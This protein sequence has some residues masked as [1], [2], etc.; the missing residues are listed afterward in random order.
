MKSKIT[1]RHIIFYSGTK[2][3][4]KNCKMQKNQNFSKTGHFL[5]KKHTKTQCSFHQ[6]YTNPSQKI[7]TTQI[8]WFAERLSPLFSFFADKYAMTVIRCWTEQCRVIKQMQSVS[9]LPRL[10]RPIS[11]KSDSITGS[12]KKRKRI[13]SC[14]E[15]RRHI[16]NWIR[17]VRS[18]TTV[19]VARTAKDGDF[20]IFV[21]CLVV[22]DGV[23]LVY[24]L[25]FWKI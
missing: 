25:I 7:S 18:V 22:R 4:H 23:Y 13:R 21:C 11:A 5:F 19:L 9:Q 1:S 8:F 12:I 15:K 10:I 6:K 16:R 17:K 20:E 24:K 14:S 3:I 2:K